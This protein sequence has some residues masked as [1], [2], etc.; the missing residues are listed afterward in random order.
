MND[1]EA[2]WSRKTMAD[3][4]PVVIGI[5]LDAEASWLGRNP[6]N[7]RR[8]VLLSHGTF[9]IREGLAPLLALLDENKIRTTFFIPGIT[10]ERYPD[11]VKEIARHNH[12]IASHT[13][14]HRSVLVI[15]PEEEEPELVKGIEA[16]EKITGVRPTTWRSASWEWSP[17]TLPLLLQHGVTVSTNFHDRVR[18]YRHQLDGKP[19]SVVELPVQWHLADAPYFVYGGEIARTIRMASDVQTIWQDEF[20]GLMEWPGSFYHLTLHVELI[21]HPGRLRMLAR[22]LQYLKSRR[23]KFLT[24]AEIAATVA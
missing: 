1:N 2:E 20:D 18:P 7:I 10:A 5:C 8:P 23:V 14:G 22:H 24:S 4:F 19:T 15:K 17:R 3:N 12:E 11:A 16:L 13:Y 21:G 9:A 6:D